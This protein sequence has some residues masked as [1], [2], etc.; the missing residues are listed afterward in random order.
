MYASPIINAASSPAAQGSSSS[1]TSSS[2]GTGIDSMF[3][4]LLITQLQNQDPLSPMDPSTFVTQLVG[5][6]TLDQVSQINQL[7]QT[8]TS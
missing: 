7:L 8:K 3:M 6:N 4:Q 1:S 5:V 2:S